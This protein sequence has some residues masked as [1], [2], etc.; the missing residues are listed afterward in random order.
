[1]SLARRKVVE[2]IKKGIGRSKG[3]AKREGIARVLE[4]TKG[5]PHNGRGREGVSLTSVS[6]TFTPAGPTRTV[7]RIVEM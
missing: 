2:A 4:P 1:M 7:F 5:T 6:H 3:Y